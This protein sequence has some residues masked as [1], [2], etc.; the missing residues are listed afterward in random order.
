MWWAYG[1]FPVTVTVLPPGGLV[2]A[3]GH[4]PWH[5]DGQS[6]SSSMVISLEV[7]KKLEAVTKPRSCHKRFKPERLILLQL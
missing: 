1:L 6:C 4:P 5:E 7:G 3:G 2:L